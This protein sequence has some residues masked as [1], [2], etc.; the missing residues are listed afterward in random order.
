MSDTSKIK[1]I[2]AALLAKA[3]GTD[4]EHEA[5][6]FMAK[7]QELLEQHQIDMGELVDG[8]DPV[9]HSTGLD[10][11]GKW[12]PSWHRHL[13]RA[14]GHLYGCKS[15]RTRGWGAQSWRQELVGRESAI[16]TTDLMFPWIVSECN[17][18][19]RGI[20][21]ETGQTAAY[22]ARRV[23]NA[24]EG[25]IWKLVKANEPKAGATSLSGRN[26]LTTI[27]RVEQVTREHYGTLV[28]GRTSGRS[29]NANAREAAAGIGLHRQATG[30]GQL[31]LK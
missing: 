8:D 31:R 2:I 21:K 28:N 14:L 29:T 3:R 1:K 11:E 10:S 23:A 26:A 22:E 20:A 27:D 7:A 12:M 25:R 9:V 17:R 16:V 13:Y 5:A 6:S 4:N 24:L 19:G 15:V 18:L 30:A